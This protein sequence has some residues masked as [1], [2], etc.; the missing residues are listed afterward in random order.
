MPCK[1]DSK[2]NNQE[3]D[4][5][6][7][8]KSR[9]REF[10]FSFPNVTGVGVG[11]KKKGGIKT[12]NITIR[13]YVSKKLLLSELKENEVIPTEIEGIST[14][15]IEGNF[16]I[17]AEPVASFQN[18]H[19]PLKGG[20]SIINYSVF[21]DR[22][23]SAGTLGGTAFDIDTRNDMILSNWHVIASGSG[24]VGDEISQPGSIDG[25]TSEDIVAKLYRSVLSSRCDAAI[26]QLDGKRYLD[27]EILGL[28]RYKGTGTP[29]IGL[30]V[31]KG[32]RTTGNTYG[33][34]VDVNADV[35]VRGYPGGDMTFEDQVVVESDDS[36][37]FSSPGDSGSIVLND[38]NEVVGLLFAGDST[39]TICNK[40]AHVMDELEVDIDNGLT[41]HDNHS[42]IISLLF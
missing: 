17:H 39:Q 10:L 5:L 12:G 7:E 13:V 27:Q 32:G 24:Q 33:E 2:E 34:I 25:G 3:F 41:L 18:H 9:N 19:N 37:P 11:F 42:S 20:I 26:A 4:R 8:I 36:S 16:S 29:S 14:D 40:I 30:S 35:T 1:M 23:L 22:I 15:V 31:K 6:Q 21:S 28:G 38:N